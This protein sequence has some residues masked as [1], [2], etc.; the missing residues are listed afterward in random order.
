MSWTHF[1]CIN[2]GESFAGRGAW[3]ATERFYTHPK[4]KACVERWYPIV[5]PPPAYSMVGNKR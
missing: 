1:R 4:H 5:D 2:C 3:K